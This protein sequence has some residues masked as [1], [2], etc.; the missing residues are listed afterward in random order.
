MIKKTK[1]K[2]TK[3]LVA[4]RGEIAI[5][6]LR[7]ANELQL[8]TVAIYAE[9]DKFSLHRFKADEA[10]RVGEGLS[11]IDAY[12]S[13]DSI[14]ELAVRVGADAIHP[15]YGFLSESP[16]FA[17]ACTGAGIIFVGP[18]ASVM[19]ALGD[20]V[21][22]R[23]LAIKAG[24]SVVPASDEL[25]EDFKTIHKIAKDVGY[26]LM[27]K[28]SWG[29]GGRGMRI[30]LNEGEL[31]K[32]VN[33]GKREAKSAFGR[34]EVYLEKLVTKARHV[35]VQIIGD[36]HGNI[37]HLFERDC[38]VQRRHQK[39]VE[40]APAPYLNT[41]Q[42]DDICTQA[43]NLMNHVGYQNAGTVE[44]LMDVDTNEFYF[45]EVNPRLQVEH[46][47]TEEI[48]GIDIVKA[49]IRIAE[50]AKI[51]DV[52]AC[53]VP[54]QNQIKVHGCAIQCRITSEDPE[55]GFVP[56]YGRITT[57]RSAMGFGI[58]LDGGGLLIQAR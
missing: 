16:D 13:I 28:A 55:N 25:P 56:D 50:G 8:K 10:Y 17:D 41:A 52:K 51:G 12:L 31:E 54:T 36:K 7:A 27:L 19:R 23:D 11:P 5:R 45:I 37:V 32:Q 14:I 43:L 6:I 35:E 48:T 40:R 29:G 24:V 21:S 4:N 53:G 18:D 47:V 22:A 33:S 15:G 34:D 38:S 39:I 58:R 42:Q 1:K 26:P 44:F 20:K 30:I 9:E 46:T 57:Y 3:L 2:I 49:Q